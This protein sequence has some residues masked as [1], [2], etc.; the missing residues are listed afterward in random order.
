[1]SELLKTKLEDNEY[2]ILANSV[3]GKGKIENQDSYKI[4]FDE[5]M[6]IICVADG[7]GSVA[8]SKEGSQKIVEI[9]CELLK[10]NVDDTLPE[11]L[12]SKW[13]KSINSNYELYDTTFKFIKIQKDVIDYGTIG[14]GWISFI[15][16]NEL[17]DELA[18]HEFSNHTDT[19]MSIGLAHK[20]IIR[21]MN[22]NLD[23]CLV[24]TDG[25]SEDIDKKDGSFM[26][27]VSE[28]MKEDC[29]AFEKELTD[30]M[31]NW[32]VKSNKDDKTLVIVKR[33]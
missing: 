16:N 30:L 15:N 14:D 21:Q 19:I 4:Y 31:S 26:K 6:I 13:K 3:M 27:D 28:T 12:R 24:S 5:S 9:G 18:D 8:F 2:I 33:I 17:I 23:V 32:P 20:F 29:E 11:K 25:F 1:M 7:L 10:D 22:N